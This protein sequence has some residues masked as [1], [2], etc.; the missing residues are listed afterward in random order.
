MIFQDPSK[1]EQDQYL[2]A[3]EKAMGMGNIDAAKEMAKMAESVPMAFPEDPPLSYPTLNEGVEFQGMQIPNQRPERTQ[4]LTPKGD[5]PMF[6][7]SSEDFQKRENDFFGYSSEKT[8]TD[9]HYW[10]DFT[11][12]TDDDIR[13]VMSK[14]YKIPVEDVAVSKDNELGVALTSIRKDGSW[15]QPKRFRSAS[16]EGEELLKGN[17]GTASA[18]GAEI[19]STI[20][21]MGTGAL[22]GTPVGSPVVGGYVGQSVGGA[23]GAYF[24]AQKR[25]HYGKENKANDY[26]DEK[27]DELATSEA[28]WALGGGVFGDVIGGV[29]KLIFGN[30]G[31]R[32]F[33]NQISTRQFNEIKAVL[34]SGKLDDFIEASGGEVTVGQI[35]EEA[36]NLGS[37]KT[38]VNI[39]EST[40]K[41]I[42][43]LEDGLGAYSPKLGKIKDIQIKKTEL[44]ADDL[45]T[46]ASTD[47]DALV[48]NQQIKKELLNNASE[49]QLV[50]E[51]GQEQI[52]QDYTAELDAEFNNMPILDTYDQVFSKLKEVKFK[53]KAKLGSAYTKFWDSVGGKNQALIDTSDLRAV[54]NAEAETL[55]R[56]AIPHMS[57]EDFSIV[58][59]VLNW[60]R[61]VKE[62]LEFGAGGVLTPVTRV[63]FEKQTFESVNRAITAL[64]A[65]KSDAVAGSVTSTQSADIRFLNKMIKS[66]E[67][68]RSDALRGIDDNAADALAKIDGDYKQGLV[69]IDEA[70]INKIL[71][72]SKSG[73]A[74]ESVVGVLSGLFGDSGRNARSFMKLLQVEGSEALESLPAIKQSIR[75]L[76]GKQVVSGEMSHKAFM[77][78][79]GEGI[80]I[81]MSPK[82]AGRF[83][84]G[85][86]GA[87]A[88]IK[89]A[90]KRS[91]TDSAEIS[92]LTGG[93]G[94]ID[95]SVLKSTLV[96]GDPD[97]TWKKAQSLTKVLSPEGLKQYKAVRLRK[98]K[99]DLLP[100][101]T[102]E[103][104]TVLRPDD[105]KTLG[106][107]VE[108]LVKTNGKELEE[109]FGATYIRDLKQ[110]GRY[111]DGQTVKMDTK[112]T[113][114][115]QGVLNSAPTP[116]MMAFRAMF[117]P[118]LS[119]KGLA[120][121]A[122]LKVSSA[123]TRRALGELLG[124][125]E[126]MRTMINLQKGYIQLDKARAALQGPLLGSLLDEV[127]GDG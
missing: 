99:R 76:Y 112:M 58:K 90:E 64:K 2:R 110:I 72:L 56:D 125:P 73:G 47:A 46:D 107:R 43:K 22:L 111:A 122:L 26:S 113:A 92:A 54:A 69:N 20:G 50:S 114:D 25:F 17:V 29:G 62:G 82:E 40:V 63:S 52:L 5:A 33:M 77:D 85:N 19:V 119:R 16:Q 30:S 39:S 80:G 66:F 60:G 48:A 38:G 51:R 67:G 94:D 103:G 68:V 44:M 81:I 23:L 98:I 18:I 42:R 41:E 97:A 93:N 71:T 14:V 70:N 101:P 127:F 11:E 86:K 118:P 116:V 9:A 4:G 124:S 55:N 34:S 27:I 57:S 3:M 21:G 108:S 120:T 89:E 74:T 91:I 36:V 102:E 61:Q 126:D 15:G 8:D 35:M 65:A 84:S 75:T 88:A 78:Q 12:G 28:Q 87:I 32:E 100:S 6:F 96:D 106:E 105:I 123:Q 95:S 1:D 37:T 83:A 31:A 53:T 59:N 24:A 13:N 45:F 117:A 115:M 79:Y 10:L 49:K 104:Q 121:T 109:L 7:E